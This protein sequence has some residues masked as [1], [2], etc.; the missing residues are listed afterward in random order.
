MLQTLIF[1]NVPTF[2]VDSIACNQTGSHIMLSGRHGISIVC[3]PQR[4]ELHSDEASDRQLCWSV[5]HL[6][7]LLLIYLTLPHFLIKHFDTMF[8]ILFCLQ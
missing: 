5:V 6:K 7:W 2:E 1:T 3:L 4:N 8:K